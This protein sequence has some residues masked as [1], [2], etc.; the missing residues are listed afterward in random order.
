M[1]WSKG[2]RIRMQVPWSLSK[3]LCCEYAELDERRVG[4]DFQRRFHAGSDLGG[5]D[6]ELIEAQW[7]SLRTIETSPG[8]STTAYCDL[9]ED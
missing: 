6:Q 8:D 3:V 2:Y 5:L 1:M 9:R 7:I 4:A